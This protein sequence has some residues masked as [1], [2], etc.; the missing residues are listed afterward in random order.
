MSLALS[1]LG[2]LLPLLLLILVGFLL[3]RALDLEDR[4]LNSV[5]LYAAVPC[6]LIHQITGDEALPWFLLPAILVTLVIVIC[7]SYLVLRLIAPAIQEAG[8]TW[9]EGPVRPMAPAVMFMS[10]AYVALPFAEVVGGE[11]GLRIAILI[12]LCAAALAY[13][14]GVYLLS[15]SVS[16]TSIFRLPLV[17]ALAVGLAVRIVHSRYQL[18][19]PELVGDTIGTIGEMASPLILIAIGAQ[20]SNTEVRH[21]RL[22]LG[23]GMLRI[24]LGG[25][26]GVLATELI[27]LASYPPSTP[28]ARRLLCMVAL[29]PSAAINAVLARHF[30][31]RADVVEAVVVSSYVLFAFFGVLLLNLL[32]V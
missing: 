16:V 30:R 26:L 8:T 18:E 22:G 11:E 9:Q 32:F 7:G 2:Q 31:F 29:L 28:L 5:V 24:C 4:S 3:G 6:L 21:F 15:G 12:Y 14:V 17:Y 27:A 20:L 1:G 19:L 25:L 13:T 10:Y 23:G